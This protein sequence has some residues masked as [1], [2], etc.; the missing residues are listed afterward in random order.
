[1][2]PQPNIL[3]SGIPMSAQA[4]YNALFSRIAYIDALSDKREA[5]GNDSTILRHK[6]SSD[7]LVNDQET[8]IVRMIAYDCLDQT[9]DLDNKASDIIKKA[10]A[11]FPGGRLNHQP[12]PQFPE[13][14]R[15]MQSQRDDIVLKARLSIKGKLGEARFAEFENQLRH[16]IQK[17]IKA[18]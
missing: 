7:L 12:I 3:Q 14:L 15:T 1:M 16:V 17:Q 8:E 6:L 18:N 4:L 5:E 9:D 13:I 11:R 10:R 2:H